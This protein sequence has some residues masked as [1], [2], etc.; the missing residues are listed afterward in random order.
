MAFQI[1]D[2][3][4]LRR[5]QAAMTASDAYYEMIRSAAS[6]VEIDADNAAEIL[7]NAGKSESDF[8]NDI[9]I[10][11]KRSKAETM[12]STAEQ[13]RQRST[14]LEREIKK[15]AIELDS[16]AEPLR[17]K[18]KAA[19]SELRQCETIAM[20]AITAKRILDENI[21]ADGS[22]QRR[23]EANAELRKLMSMEQA[24][25]SRL[26][27][28][29]RARALQAEIDRRQG[30][31]AK[32]PDQKGDTIHNV[33]DQ[34]QAD[35]ATWALQNHNLQ[36]LECETQLAAIRERRRELQQ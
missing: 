36:V 19:N 32:R 24:I 20:S 33:Y 18:I 16:V 9:L 6:G 8:E 26:P 10:L 7:D 22:G 35:D 1:L 25:L 30:N 5:K 21:L 17:Q 28:K 23:A 2:R 13:A 15:L 27:N 11:A 4:R 29:N 14:I 12:L 3:L 31:I 34:T